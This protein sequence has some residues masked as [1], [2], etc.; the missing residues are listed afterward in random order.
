MPG[1]M[2]L[3]NGSFVSSCSL[4]RLE[5]VVLMTSRRPLQALQ[6][7]DF[8]QIP[9]FPQALGEWQQCSALRVPREEQAPSLDSPFLIFQ[10]VQIFTK[11]EKIRFQ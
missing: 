2:V 9:C 8:S 1:A 3:L 6:F 4:G 10:R 11:T 5:L 7:C